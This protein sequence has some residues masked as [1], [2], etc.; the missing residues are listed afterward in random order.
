MKRQF[1]NKVIE[2]SVVLQDQSVSGVLVAETWFKSRLKQLVKFSAR[3]SKVS[4]PT[5]V[6]SVEVWMDHIHVRMPN[7]P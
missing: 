5:P 2:C 3:D 6:S 4:S 1:S 7:L